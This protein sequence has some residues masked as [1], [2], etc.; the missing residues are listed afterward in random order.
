MFLSHVPSLK[1]FWDYVQDNPRTNELEDS[2]VAYVLPAGYA[3]GF[4]GPDDKVWGLWEADEFAY[5][6]AVE[7][8]NLLEQYG[9]ELDIIYD[10]G[11]DPDNTSIYRKLVFWNGTI[12]EQ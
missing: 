4:R 6:T 2:R 9:S 1:Q 12:C 5:K 10:D 7:L 3:Y 8:S 11:L